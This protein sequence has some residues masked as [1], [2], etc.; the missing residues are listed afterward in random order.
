MIWFLEGQSSQRDVIQAARR[1]LPPQIMVYAS[2]TSQRP[3]ITSV[4]DIALLEPKDANIR[5]DWV[6]K[7]AIANNIRVVLAGKKIAI[8][9]ARRA[10]FA[11]AGITLVTG[12]QCVD[13]LRL[14]SK[15][16]FTDECRAA[17][18]A[19]V[20]GIAVDN[21]EQL[22]AAYQQLQNTGAVCIKP[23][24]GIYGAGFWQF[25]ENIDPFTCLAYP[26]KRQIRFENYL[27]MFTESDNQRPQLVMPYMPGDEV[28]TD[29]VVEAGTP[30]AWV[31]RRK[32][33]IYQYFEN[34]GSAVDL[35]LDAV[36]HFGLDGIISVQTKDDSEGRPHLLEINLRY[37]GGIAYTH[38]SGINLPGIFSCRR[39]G[40]AVPDSQ[41]LENIQIK[42][43]TSAISC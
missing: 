31:G 2:H 28:S 38:L 27:Q 24:N 7:T 16:V 36:S 17:G 1:A 39:L 14:E 21:P 8:Y 6:L 41:W 15:A 10:D 4:A 32:K 11:A 18:L 37:S 20:P 13:Q 3:E 9:E 42:A 30:I 19:V 43:I 25:N 23:V 29:I 40:L 22:A 12:V 33:G 34:R 5:V 26:D 35:A